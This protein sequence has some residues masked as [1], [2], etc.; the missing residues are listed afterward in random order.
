MVNFSSYSFVK[1]ILKK[2][3]T[4]FFTKCKVISQKGNKLSRAKITK[5]N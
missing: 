4:K 1:K 5:I 2:T 3:L